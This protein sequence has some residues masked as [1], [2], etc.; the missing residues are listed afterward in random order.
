MNEELDVTQFLIPY[1]YD[2][3]SNILLGMINPGRLI[4]AVLFAAPFIFV[5]VMF[6][7]IL[8]VRIILF[9]LAAFLFLFG[10]VGWKEMGLFQFFKILF[11]WIKTPK[12]FSMRRVEV[13]GENY[14]K[15]RQR[16]RSRKEKTQEKQKKQKRRKE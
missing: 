11:A 7:F 9:M 2:T 3:P 4:Q 14:A 12:K 15:E 10:L 5:A 16:K 1:N 6:P 13:K 8:I